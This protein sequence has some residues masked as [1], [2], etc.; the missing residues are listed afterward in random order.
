MMKAMRTIRIGFLKGGRVAAECL[1]F[2]EGE[3]QYCIAVGQ[4]IW[5]GSRFGLI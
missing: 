2:E 5:H 4:F 3:L 1:S